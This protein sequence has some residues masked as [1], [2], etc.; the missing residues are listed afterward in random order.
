M[1]GSRN[2]GVIVTASLAG[3][4]FGFDTVVISG[5]T[6][7]VRSVFHLVPG[8]FWDGF[9]VASG[10]LGTF[11]GALVAGWPGDAFGSRDT[12]KAVGFMYVVSALGCA[13]CWNLE[14][15]YVFRFVGGLAIGAS[16]VLAP[17]YISEIAP[18]ERRGA[19]T[20]LFQFNIVFGILVA[21]V[22]NF[23]VQ[24][25]SGG[26]DLWR[27]K[28]GIAAVPAI[29]FA[30]LMYTIPQSPRWLALRGRTAEAKTNLAIVGVADPDAMLAEFDR[31][32]RLARENSAEKLFVAAY[33]K[34]IVL[35]ILLAM[36]NQ[37]SG[38]NAIL[39]YL[40]DIF[41]AAG[42]TGWSNALQAV[43]I[44]AANLIATMI[45]LRFIDRI[46]RKKLLLIGAIGTACA[47]AGVAVIMG[48]GQ[49]KGLLLAMLI[50]F[51]SFFAFSQGAVIWVYLAEIFPT[52]VRS[53]GQALGSA[54][55][56][57]MNAIIG[58]LFPMI[59]IYTQALPF[60]FFAACMVLQFFVVLAIFP[61]TRGVELESMD[62]A[63]ARGSG[64]LR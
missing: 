16:S 11:I 51:I 30:V 15:F 62:K 47:L 28:L 3:L 8:S 45:A 24:E 59:A 29:L 44:G 43:A 46:G 7:S 37:L 12:L 40:N 61:E 42:F 17:V 18:A 55:H 64:G 35:A 4:L 26:A 33:R 54:T 9:A 60:A 13:F 34:P 25:M 53:R 21:Y 6:E 41:A 2:L 14:S 23:A 56:W 63:L 5:V 52:A 49:G 27:L 20:G 50:V 1:A 58:Q 10:L 36:F 38:I 48:T 22:S 19:L 39:Y 32:A 57:G 31:A